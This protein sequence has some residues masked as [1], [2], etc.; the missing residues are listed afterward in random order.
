MII[1]VV[2]TTSRRRTHYGDE[3]WFTDRTELDETFWDRGG[4]ESV[5]PIAT[6]PITAEPTSAL[7]PA[8]PTTQVTTGDPGVCTDAGL[9]NPPTTA[10]GKDKAVSIAVRGALQD[11]IEDVPL[12]YMAQ[13]GS[14]KPFAILPALFRRHQ[15]N[16]AEMDVLNEFRGPRAGVKTMVQNAKRISRYS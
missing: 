14:P 7:T 2:T 12:L 15:E 4:I 11:A 13:R 8:A 6:A 1:V 10:L 3:D 9:S 5:N 16:H